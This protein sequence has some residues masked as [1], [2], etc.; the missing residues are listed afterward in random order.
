MLIVTAGFPFR[1]HAEGEDPDFSDTNYW[2]SL[3]TDTDSLSDEDVKNCQAYTQYMQERNSE[4]Q[5]QI[6][7]I[8][9]RKE[10]ISAKISDYDNQ[11]AQFNAQIEGITGMI[12]DLSMQIKAV[13]EQI[14]DIQ[15]RIDANQKAIVEKQNDVDALKE[16]VAKRLVEEQKTMRTYQFLDVLMGAASFEDFVRLANGMNDIYAHDS[17][18]LEQLTQSIDSLHEME[19]QLRSDQ[20]EV[21][22]METELAAGKQ[23]LDSQQ[24]ALLS[25]RYELQILQQSY[26]EQLAAAD[27][28]KTSAENAIAANQSQIGNIK[29]SIANR[30]EPTPTAVPETTA[31][32]DSGENST[33]DT[34][35]ESSDTGAAPASTATPKPASTPASSSGDSS[36]PPETGNTDGNPY[37]GGWANCTWGTWQ[38]VHDTLGISL[39]GWGMA[40]NWM[41][42]AA[43]SGYATGS[44]PKV[45]SIA[46]YSWHVGFVTAVDGD[47]VYIKEGNYLGHYYERWVPVEGLPYSGQTCLG[48]IYL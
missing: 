20:E 3:C 14:A 4:L 37:Y 1:V 17:H 24:A 36:T 43:R 27:Q 11:I 6:A 21:K 23:M 10:E 7:D 32:A 41:N 39:P 42:D 8:D 30:P 35:P 34:T 5:S 25:S 47:R 33:P 45:Y 19:D 9:A 44:T 40:G 38:L 12:Q 31:S 22:T 28:E 16:K 26:N 18:S 46:V 29:D 13:E 15:N 2:N 48:Y